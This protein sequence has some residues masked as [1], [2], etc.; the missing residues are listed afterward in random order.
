MEGEIKQDDERNLLCALD[1][2]VVV[3]LSESLAGA[4]C[5]KLLVDAGATGI[6]VEPAAGCAIRSR[7]P[8]SPL[9]SYLEIGRAHV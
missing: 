5:V 2:M 1:G 9:F 3:D 6:R 7:S 8:G 4:Y